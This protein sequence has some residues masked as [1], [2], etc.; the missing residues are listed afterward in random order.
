MTTILFSI[1]EERRK[2]FIRYASYPIVIKFLE[3]NT[4]TDCIK[5]SLKSNRTEP[6]NNFDLYGHN[7]ALQHLKQHVL[8]RNVSESHI[9]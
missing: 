2:Q 8:L 9:D 3:K 1:K 4:V 6:V 5:G 7:N